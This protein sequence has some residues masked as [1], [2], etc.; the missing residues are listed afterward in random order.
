MPENLLSMLC[1]SAMAYGEDFSARR[2]KKVLFWDSASS[3]VQCY[4]ARGGSSALI[5]FRGS[6]EL[7]D[8]LTCLRFSK[9]RFI[10]KSKVH[11][12]F[13]R[14]YNESGILGE[15]QKSLSE[16][17]ISEIFLTGHSLGAA[18]AAICALDLA[19]SYEKAKIRCALFG[20]PRIGDAAFAELFGEI[21]TLRTENGN[22][23]VCRLPPKLFGFSHIGSLYH[24]GRPRRA[25]S[26]SLADHEIKSYIKTLQKERGKLFRHD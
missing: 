23:L 22:D 4:I 20:S 6:D 8:L 15:I 21:F 24:M 5:A 26:F 16:A 12:G 18:L 13:L 25:L 9:E 14:A 19:R 10:G 7:K 3:G 2:Y 11:K 17:P 1:Y